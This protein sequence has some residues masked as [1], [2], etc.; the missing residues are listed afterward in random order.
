MKVIWTLAFTVV[1][2]IICLVAMPV[3]EAADSDSIIVSGIG[4]PP[5][6]AQS[7]AQALLMAKRAARVDALRNDTDL[8]NV[9]KH[10]EFRVTDYKAL[11]ITL[12]YFEFK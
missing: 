4:Y 10:P 12:A 3:I 5:I 9:R 1:F 8:N 7:E 11:L 2:L 6:K